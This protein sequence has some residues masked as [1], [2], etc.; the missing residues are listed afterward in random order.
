LTADACRDHEFRRRKIRPTCL[1][2]QARQLEQRVCDA[3]LRKDVEALDR[4][5]AL[6]FTLRVA[7]VPQSSL[8]RTIWMD[9][10][11]RL[12]PESCEQRYHAARKLAND[13]AVVS[14]LQTQQ[15]TSDGRDFSDDFYIVDFLKRS[16]GDWRILPLSVCY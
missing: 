1:T 16:S 3:I 9:N 8:P 12:K 11:K 13:L 4:L 6:E 7:D 15:T 10:V 14:L 5:V 2:E